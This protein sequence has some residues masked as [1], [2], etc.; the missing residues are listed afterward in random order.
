MLEIMKERAVY[1]ALLHVVSLIASVPSLIP[2]LDSLPD[3][4]QSLA[5]LL[6]TLS[7]L[8]EVVASK[9]LKAGPLGMLFPTCFRSPVFLFCF[10][11][12]R[13]RVVH[14]VNMVNR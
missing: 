10:S 2:L 1:S 14:Y 4:R 9:S 7:S 13:S 11:M 3:Q 5:Q 8:T 6:S 12:L